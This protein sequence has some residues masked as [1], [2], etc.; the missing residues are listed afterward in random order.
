M[1]NISI[2]TP[3]K[4]TLKFGGVPKSS[5]DS[6][7]RTLVE[8]KLVERFD[9]S[10]TRL[11][12]GQRIAITHSGRAHIRLALEEDVYFEQAALT[13]GLMRESFAEDIRNAISA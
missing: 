13:T 12:R 7:I 3:C 6:A 1:N 9:P 10:D 2:L 4:I 11:H 8:N 5:V